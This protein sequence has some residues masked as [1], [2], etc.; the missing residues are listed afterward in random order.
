MDWVR[1]SLHLLEWISPD[2]THR[3]QSPWLLSGYSLWMAC[4]STSGLTQ[5]SRL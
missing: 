3:Y 1:D 5:S 2:L 4:M